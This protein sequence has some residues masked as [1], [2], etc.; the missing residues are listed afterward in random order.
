V[1][2]LAPTLTAVW[3]HFLP[4]YLP[5]LGESVPDVTEVDFEPGDAY[6]RGLLRRATVRE[7]LRLQGFPDDFVLIGKRSDSY[8]QVGNAVNVNVVH[9]LLASVIPTLDGRR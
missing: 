5:A 6:G 9:A 4:F 3:S 7:T 1:D 2:G 8:K